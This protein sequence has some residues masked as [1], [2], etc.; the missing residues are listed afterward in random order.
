MSKARDDIYEQ[1]E[2]LR[3]GTQALAAAAPDD[4][5]LEQPYALYDE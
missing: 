2:D 3:A 1:A 4:V 5:V